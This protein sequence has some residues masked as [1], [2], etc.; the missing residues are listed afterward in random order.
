MII[1]YVALL[2]LTFVV[3]RRTYR[4][5]SIAHGWSVAFIMIICT[6]LLPNDY[7][8]QACEWGFWDWSKKHTQWTQ[9]TRERIGI[10]LGLL[11]A[12]FFIYLEKF[13]IKTAVPSIERVIKK[14]F[15]YFKIP[16]KI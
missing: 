13:L 9:L 12:L 7:I 10:V 5:K 8:A 16:H 3:A 14:S 11:V 1:N 4:S 6:Y 2:G 15:V